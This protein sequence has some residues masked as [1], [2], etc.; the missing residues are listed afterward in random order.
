[1]LRYSGGGTERRGDAMSFPQKQSEKSFSVIKREGHFFFIIRMHSLFS[2][3]SWKESSY[4][5]SDWIR[6]EGY[7]R[8]GRDF[9]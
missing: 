3:A 5:K 1:M 2:Y 9:G 8:Q 7:R 6:G 4:G